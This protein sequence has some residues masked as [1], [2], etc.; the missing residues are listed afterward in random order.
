VRRLLGAYV[1]LEPGR[2]AF[3]TGAHGKPRLAAGPEF[4]LSHSGATMLLA[5]SGAGALGVDIERRGRLDIDWPEVTRRVFSDAERAQLDRMADAERA[6]AALRGWVRKEAY[7]KARG[8]GFAYDFCA[9]TVDLEP[10][11]SGSL[12]RADSQD[13]RACAEWLLVDLD[14]GPG[15][16]ASLAYSGQQASIL[17]RSEADWAG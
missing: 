17:Y 8:A 1:G 4:N 12:L 6:A 11:A 15:L 3:E 16:A 13:E 2:L 14:S 5:V 7:A 9:F 10:A